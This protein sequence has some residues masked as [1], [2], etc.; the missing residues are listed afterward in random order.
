[1]SSARVSVSSFFVVIGLL[2]LLEL[3]FISK[4]FFVRLEGWYIWRPFVELVANAARNRSDVTP[5]LPFFAANSSL[6]SFLGD[7]FFD[8]LRDRA[9]MEDKECRCGPL[10]FAHK[11][12]WGEKQLRSIRVRL[13]DSSPRILRDI[14]VYESDDPGAD[15]KVDMWL[16]VDPKNVSDSSWSRRYSVIGVIQGTSNASQPVLVV[17]KGGGRSRLCHVRNTTSKMKLLDMLYLMKQP[18]SEASP[19][20]AGKVVLEAT[21]AAWDSALKAKRDGIASFDC[22]NRTAFLHRKRKVLGRIRACHEKLNTSFIDPGDCI[23]SSLFAITC[24]AYEASPNLSHTIADR[25]RMARMTGSVPIVLQASGAEQSDRA[26]MILAR[27]EQDLLNI[28]DSIDDPN[29]II[30]EYIDRAQNT[31]CSMHKARLE[32]HGSWKLV[33]DMLEGASSEA[34]KQESGLHCPSESI[35]E[36]RGEALARRSWILG[37]PDAIL[38]GKTD[39]RSRN[40]E[41][42]N[43]SLQGNINRSTTW[44]LVSAVLFPADARPQF[45]GKLR[46]FLSQVERGTLLP[47]EV[48]FTV[49]AIDETDA[50]LLREIVA[51]LGLSF[52][53]K[54][55]PVKEKLLQAAGRNLAFSHSSGDIILLG[56]GD[57]YIHPQKLEMTKIIFDVNPDVQVLYHDYFRSF[58]G[59]EDV[60][61]MNSIVFTW[62]SPQDLSSRLVD[63]NKYVKEGKPQP[64]NL[65]P[66]LFWDE[67]YYNKLTSMTAMKRK[68]FERVKQRVHPVYYREEDARHGLD[69]L[70]NGFRLWYTPHPLTLYCR[71][72]DVT[73]APFRTE[74][75][76]A[77]IQKNLRYHVLNESGTVWM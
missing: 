60:A 73:I 45:V 6:S 63:L 21:E 43:T 1:M 49:S 25:V 46:T 3:P 27:T 57:D 11:V 69:L 23:A 4:V 39:G 34:G 2:C 22:G 47:M 67:Q 40:S 44:S 77:I 64:S 7:G 50:H 51:E 30:S 13:V 65:L 19:L 38:R 18:P 9:K 71:R 35:L 37:F 17:P 8:L 52:D 42:F 68:L 10:Q 59:P 62:D 36:Q 15:F 61:A 58:C 31:R 56:D 70:A 54:I 72:A 48:I 20:S 24:E 16:E 74:F 53:V 66:F 33:L 41:T 29:K 32:K 26:D 28:L 76:R 14:M 55:V 5:E 75:S 12:R